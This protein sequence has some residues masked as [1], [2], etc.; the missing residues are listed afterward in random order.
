[1]D[2]SDNDIVYVPDVTANLGFSYRIMGRLFVAANCVYTGRVF[3]NNGNT[4]KDDGYGVVNS[5]LGYEMENFDIYLW[6]KNLFNGKY[7]ATMVDFR[8]YGGGLSARLGD[9]QAFGITV[10]Y[11]FLFIGAVDFFCQLS[12]IIIKKLFRVEIVLFRGVFLG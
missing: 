7:A 8:G 2:Y 3:M 4:L 11:R 10:A 1:M 6:S 5:K 9:L 12:V